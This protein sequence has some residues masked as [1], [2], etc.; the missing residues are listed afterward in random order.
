[1][2]ITVKEF[3][4]NCTKLVDHVSRTNETIQIT[5]RGKVDAEMK[6]VPS[7]ERKFSGPGSAKGEMFIVGDIMEPLDVKWEVLEDGD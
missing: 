2:I 3:E 1:M 7:K 5:K 6:G 4:G